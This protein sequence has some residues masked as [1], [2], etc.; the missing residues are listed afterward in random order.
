MYLLEIPRI[1]PLSVKALLS[2]YRRY[3]RHSPLSI[4][5]H[6]YMGEEFREIQVKSTLLRK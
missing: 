3:A 2:H 6:E 1:S 4:P 5:G